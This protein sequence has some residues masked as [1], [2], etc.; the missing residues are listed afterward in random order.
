MLRSESNSVRF[1]IRR[2]NIRRV[3]APSVPFT[4][5]KK[6]QNK[7]KQ[8]KTERKNNNN[9]RVDGLSIPRYFE[10]GPLEPG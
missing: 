9:D 5:E 7:T 3:H 10:N 2:S 1:R 8:N 6:K 4:P